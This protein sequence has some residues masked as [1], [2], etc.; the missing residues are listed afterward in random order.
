MKCCRQKRQLQR[1]QSMNKKRKLLLVDDETEFLETMARFL[2][3]R[4]IECETA[5]CCSQALDWLAREDFDVAVT[6][7]SMPGLDGLK[8]MEEMKKIQPALEVIIL[9]G[10]GSLSSGLSGM[11]QGAYTYCLKPID[12]E[13]LLEMILLARQAY[14]EMAS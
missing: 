6:D 12:F 10:H 9:T 7:M 8:C 5:D 2:R 11:K 4:N 3:K 13:E 14:R 1:G